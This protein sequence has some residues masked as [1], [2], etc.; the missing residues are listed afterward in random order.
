MKEKVKPKTLSFF[1]FPFSFSDLERETRVE[2]A[3]ST[4]ARSRSTTELLPHVANHNFTVCQ[5]IVK[6]TRLLCRNILQE[7]PITARIDLN[8]TDP[9]VRNYDVCGIPKRQKRQLIA[10]DLPGFAIEF[11][12]LCLVRRILS[13]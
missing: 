5:S 1:L 11:L 10:R 3:T 2:L 7:T 8:I 12:S 13:V 6:G 9:L 4:L